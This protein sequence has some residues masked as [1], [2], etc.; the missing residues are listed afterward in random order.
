[1]IFPLCVCVLISSSYKDTSHVGQGLT[2]MTSFYLDY[3]FKDPV[4]KYSHIL[5]YGGL[6]LN[7]LLGLKWIW[8]NTQDRVRAIII[9]PFFS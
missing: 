5:M 4:S 1:M 2:P 8:G 3:L 7:E 6:G 9:I